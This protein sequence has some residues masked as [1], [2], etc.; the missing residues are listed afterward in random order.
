MPEF[1]L[2]ENQIGTLDKD[3]A[4]LTHPERDIFGGVYDKANATRKY[5]TLGG[6]RCFVAIPTGRDSDDNTFK[7]THAKPAPKAE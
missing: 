3:G 4:I 1:I 7:M 2:E 6:K 5:L